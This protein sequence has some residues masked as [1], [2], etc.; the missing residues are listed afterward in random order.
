[1]F[2]NPLISALNILI[3]NPFSSPMIYLSLWISYLFVCFFSYRRAEPKHP[4]YLLSLSFSV[5]ICFLFCERIFYLTIS[6]DGRLLIHEN[7]SLCYFPLVTLEIHPQSLMDF[8]AFAHLPTNFFPEQNLV[9][10]F[11]TCRSVM[12]PN[13][14]H[15]FLNCS[16]HSLA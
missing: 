14:K 15:F 16:R 9:N 1:M 8:T 6:V 12:T 5:L 13:H 4:P 3:C 2:V 10:Q 11:P 7:F